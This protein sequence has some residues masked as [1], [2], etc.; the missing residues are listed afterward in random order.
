VSLDYAVEQLARELRQR[1][2]LPDEQ[3]RMVAQWHLIRVAQAVAIVT[4]ER[5][6]QDLIRFNRRGV[7]DV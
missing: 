5:I 7:Q 4:V 3:A 2:G 6:N 1:F